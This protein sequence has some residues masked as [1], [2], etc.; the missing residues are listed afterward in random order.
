LNRHR[1]MGDDTI[2]LPI[3]RDMTNLF[4]VHHEPPEV[5]RNWEG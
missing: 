4:P 5:D 2:P 1:P 3:F